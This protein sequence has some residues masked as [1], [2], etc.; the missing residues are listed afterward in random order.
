M[1][2]YSAPVVLVVIVGLTLGGVSKGFIGLGL[3]LVAVPVLTLVVDVPTAIALMIGPILV[4]NVW[5]AVQGGQWRK[6]LARFWPLLATQPIGTF[7]GVAVLALA[8]PRLVAGLLGLMV[9]GFSLI[10]QFQPQW[11]ISAR[12]ERLA[13]PLMGIVSGV[14][15][16]L[17]SFLGTPVAMYLFALRL[18]KQPF[19]GAIG[20]TFGFGTLVL[21]IVMSLF[22]LFTVAHS[23][24]TILAILPMVA[25]MWLGRKLQHRVS[26]RHFRIA[27][28]SVLIV[29]GLNL[30]RRA[31]F[32]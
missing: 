13:T 9:V 24:A 23:V 26:E 18:D 32:A 19:I 2:E 29:I 25:G 30:I 4:S 16:G 28:L 1:L 22:G 20:L 21:L 11:R 15:G 5:Q 27:L 17:S 10:V 3:P 14:F 8:D 6:Q 7:A 12:A 31:L